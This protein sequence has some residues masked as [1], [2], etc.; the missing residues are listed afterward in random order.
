MR[1]HVGVHIHTHT[2]RNARDS[3]EICD[4]EFKSGINDLT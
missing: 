4:S 2:L 1:A 3:D